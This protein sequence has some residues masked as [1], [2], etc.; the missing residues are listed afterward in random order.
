MATPNPDPDPRAHGERGIATAW[1]IAWIFVCLTIGW[2]AV[3]ATA[4][5]ADQ[6]RLDD[7]ADLSSLSAAAELQHGGPACTVAAEIAS[8][9]GAGLHRC[10]VDGDDVVV[11]VERG[12]SL[13]FGVRGRLTSTARAGP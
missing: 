8:H 6:H 2:V 7:A 1:G 11:T 9:N 10:R 3:V 4:V 5:V 13:P 12:L